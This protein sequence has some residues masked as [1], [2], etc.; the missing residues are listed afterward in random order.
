MKHNVKDGS[1]L[2][3]V[4]TVDNLAFIRLN[5]PPPSML[6]NTSLYRDALCLRFGG[7]YKSHFIHAGS[8]LKTISKVITRIQTPHCANVL[9]CFLK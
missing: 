1:G 6:S 2:D 8:H 4:G 7:E 5:G 3:D 9:P